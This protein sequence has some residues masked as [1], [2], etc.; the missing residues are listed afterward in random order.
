M[1]N[2]LK[3]GHIYMNRKLISTFI[4]CTLLLTGC[5]IP[6]FGKKNNQNTDQNV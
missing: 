3:G 6:G 5:T 1:V 4:I 2:G